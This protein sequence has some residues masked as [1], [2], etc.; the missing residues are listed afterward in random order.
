MEG[1]MRN[2][3]RVEVKMKPLLG[4]AIVTSCV[5]M[6]SFSNVVT[7]PFDFVDTRWVTACYASTWAAVPLWI[8]VVVKWRRKR[9]EN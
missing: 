9:T 8:A 5:S 3:I 1:A 4:M 7:M 6:L 2:R